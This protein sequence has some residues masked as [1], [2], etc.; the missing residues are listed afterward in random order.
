MLRALLM[1]SVLIATL[2]SASAA[3]PAPNTLSDEE[4]KEGWILLFDGTSLDQWKAF[5]G[6]GPAPASWK[7]VDGTLA[8]PGKGG[9]DLATK[10]QY[11]NFELKIDWKISP[12]GNSGVMY[13]STEEGGAPYMTGPEI[14]VLDN[15]KHA[16][17]KNPKTS[18]GSCYHMYPPTKDVT[19]PVGEWNSFH[20]IADGAKLTHVLNG[21]KVCEYEIGSA[22]WKTRLATSKWAKAALYATKTKGYIVLQD[23]GNPVWF[24]NIKIKPL[25]A[26]PAK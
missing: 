14:Q 4:K 6:G 15:Q 9:G 23:H 26:T 8:L 16:D 7:A 18:S 1:S 24:R 25:A 12:G 2:A 5:K 21:E 11:D 13:R 3:D 22:D 17:G 10:E 20:I 19:K